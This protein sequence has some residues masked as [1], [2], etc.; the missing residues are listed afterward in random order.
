M[1]I[2]S[3][4]P[5][6]GAGPSGLV[7]ALSLLRNGVPVRIIEKTTHPRIGQR[8]AGIMPRSFEVFGFLGI[9]DK[10]IARGRSLMKLRLWKTPGGVEV[11]KEMDMH[12][13]TD[14]TP[15]IPYPNMRLCGQNNL[16]TI[17]QAELKECGVSV[18]HGVQLDSF[19]QFSDHVQVQL[20]KQKI[21]TEEI[22]RE[23]ASYDYV[24][25]C[26]GARGIVRKLLGLTF[27][28]QTTEE[29]FVVGDIKLEGL[30]DDRWNL[31]SEFSDIFTGIRPTED[32]GVFN[33]IIGGTK[34]EN[35]A[36][37]ASNDEVLKSF[38]E[39]H[40]GG[41]KD[42]KIK[43]F[44]TYGHYRTHIRM[45]NK[46]GEGRV[47]VAG[48][49]AHIHSP[50]GGQGLN[51]GVQDAFNLGWKL[52]LVTKGLSPASLLDTYN[53]ERLPVVAEMLNITTGI[54]NATRAAPTGDA[55]KRTGALMQLGVNYRW[56]SIVVDEPKERLDQEGTPHVC[57]FRV[58]R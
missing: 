21:G 3:P 54:L 2:D 45:V 50:T 4:L 49:A 20:S 11:I 41:R 43:E 17:M 18:E 35:H 7:L 29:N 46:F 16:D 25:G 39:K 38:I 48:D 5:P 13:D 40:T 55:W 32:K 12:T 24:V 23:D 9:A 44:I 14:P 34:F 6:V 37:V 42:M 56:S 33:F 52:S 31:W 36:E 58:L 57:Y 30:S 28:G 27:L 8:G 22:E 26:D 47:F 15:S 19:E 51:T 10:V 53:D 1:A